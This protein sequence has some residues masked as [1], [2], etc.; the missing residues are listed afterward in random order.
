M[1]R[2]E[3]ALGE[4]NEVTLTTLDQL[5]GELEGKNHSGTLKIVAN[6]ASDYTSLMDF[7]KAGP[8]YERTLEGFEAQF[9]K[10]HTDTKMCAENYQV[11][12]QYRGNN[13]ERLA[14]LKRTYP[15]LK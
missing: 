13:V 5:G 8:L 9:G 11:C 7:G 3:K 2:T 10:D 15:H 1:K 14:Q 6:I 12:L 4:K